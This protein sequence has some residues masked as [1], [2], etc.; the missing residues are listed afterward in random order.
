LGI[1]AR[2][3][4]FGGS[5]CV[6]AYL[7]VSQRGRVGDWWPLVVA[8]GLSASAVG[9][10]LWRL[11]CA[12]SQSVSRRRGALAGAL[13]GL[14]AHPVA[15]YLALVWNYLLGHTSSLGDTPSG[16]LESLAGCLVMTFWSLLIVGWLTVP[17]GAVVGFLLARR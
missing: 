16:P 11:L 14:L 12:T 6:L 1:V 2:A 13:T 8:S 17:A 5:G 4:V 7:I 15:W 3:L 10:L 9:L